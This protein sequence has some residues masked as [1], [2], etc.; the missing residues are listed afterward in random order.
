MKKNTR[1]KMLKVLIVFVVFMF[2]IG[3]LPM[4][5]Y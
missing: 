1:D 3:L 5:F 4:F 2:I